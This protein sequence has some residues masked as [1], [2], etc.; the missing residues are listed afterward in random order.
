MAA[1][2]ETTHG[3]LRPDVGRAVFE[4]IRRPPSGDLAGHVERHWYVR[5]D[6]HGA[7]SFTQEILPH[8]CVNL[9]AEPGLIAVHGIPLGRSPH[10]LDGA[11]IAIGTKFR[12]G[13]FGGFLD[14]PASELNGR[15]VA[16]GE[17]FGAAGERLERRLAGLD[18]DVDEHIEAVEAFLRERLPAPDPRHELV[19]AV[20]DGMLVAGPGTTVAQLA[21]RHAV[22]A[23][24]LQRVFAQFVG[25]GP[26]WVL[27]RYR[28]HE[29]A[30]RIAAGEA[31]DGA[32][33]A[34]DLGYFDQSHFIRDFTAQIGM[35][36]SVYERACAAAAGRPVPAPV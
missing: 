5:W 22:S 29:A 30:E 16:L 24:T 11:G 1:A 2:G 6:L 23:R 27:K 21:E 10:R 7:P 14:R 9:V 26:K 20:V 13:G 31:D 3:I 36:P 12:P 25:V 34:L 28:M 15:A 8:P 33:L 19:R 4:L 17:L 32:S 35:P 18:G